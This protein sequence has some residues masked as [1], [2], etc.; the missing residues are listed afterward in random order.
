MD[1]LDIRFERA[2]S[3]VGRMIE[4]NIFLLDDHGRRLHTLSRI[5]TFV[6][7]LLEDG[8]TLK[9]IIRK[10]AYKFGLSEEVADANTREFLDELAAKGAV[11]V[12]NTSRRGLR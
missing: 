7:G 5:G 12:F 10:V 2:E 6:W 8:S 11:R 4:G 9:E 1:G 3:I